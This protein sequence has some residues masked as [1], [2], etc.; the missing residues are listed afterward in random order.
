MAGVMAR[1]GIEA[2]AADVEELRTGPRAVGNC[3]LPLGAALS[4]GL[5]NNVETADI[6][7]C[8]T[9]TPIAADATEGALTIRCGVDVG[10]R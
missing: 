3:V 10:P 2:R 8:R 9:V 7:G 6:T 1:F 5:W 4:P